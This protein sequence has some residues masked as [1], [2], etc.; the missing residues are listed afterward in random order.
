M[1]M[2][3]DMIRCDYIGFND[4]FHK[5]NWNMIAFEKGENS[6]FGI[7]LCYDIS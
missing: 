1:W 3:M 2:S 4:I 7:K 6:I 5:K